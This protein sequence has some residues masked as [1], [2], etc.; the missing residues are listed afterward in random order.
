MSLT[1]HEEGSFRE[2]WTISFPLM[3][4]SLSVM[5]MLFVDRIFLAKFSLDAFNAAVAAGTLGWAFIVGAMVLTSI[6][7]VFV[8]QFNGAS[9]KDKLGEP[10]WQM[11]WLA[12]AMFFIFYPLSRLGSY[13]FFGTSDQMQMQ[14]DYFEWMMLFGPAFPLYGALSGFFVGQGKVKIITRLAFFANFVNAGLDWIMIFGIPHVFPS[15]GVKGAAIATCT[16]QLFQVLVLFYFFL[17]KENRIECQTG[18]YSIRWRSMYQCIRI[19]SPGAVFITL[20][21]LGW[22]IYYQFMTQAGDKHITIAGICQSLIILLFFFTEGLQKGVTTIVGN[23]IGSKK[24]HLVPSTIYS[25]IKLHALF[26]FVMVAGLTL[27]REAITT[28]F[29]STTEAAK[30]EKYADALPFCIATIGIYLFFEGVRF[31]FAG[32]L[33]A[34]GDTMFLLATGCITIWVFLITPVYYIVVKGGA[35][36]EVSSSICAAYAGLAVLIN[37]TRYRQGKWKTIVITA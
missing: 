9:R 27:F 30:I 8:A 17:K 28:Q 2:L 25:G 33:T 5:T 1:K 7:E 29:F 32:V 6:S 37:L 18:D 21:I 15:L 36:I 20:E 34:A 12:G 11:I 14:R 19:G 10:V 31:L 35:S 26:F 3:L 22:A 16:C 4:S 13:W 23:L 24:T